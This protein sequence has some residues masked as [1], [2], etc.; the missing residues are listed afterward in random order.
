MAADKSD[1]GR[2]LEELWNR[3]AHLKRI[4]NSFIM[5]IPKKE[6]PKNVGEFKSIAI[7]NITLKIVLKCFYI[8]YQPVE[9]YDS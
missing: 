3:R 1:L 7:L 8:D 9:K 4:N 2:L 5:L 6:V